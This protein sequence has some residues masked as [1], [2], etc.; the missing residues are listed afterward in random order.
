VHV[1]PFVI[2]VHLENGSLE[3]TEGKSEIFLQVARKATKT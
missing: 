1:A 3:E 2:L